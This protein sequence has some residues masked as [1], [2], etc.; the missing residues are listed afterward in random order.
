LQVANHR[1]FVD[2]GSSAD[3]QYRSAFK[4]MEI[5]LEKVVLATCPLIGFLGEQVYSVGANLC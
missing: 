3:I 5:S 1:I 4:N 2:N